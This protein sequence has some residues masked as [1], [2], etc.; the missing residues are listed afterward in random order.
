MLK[1]HSDARPHLAEFRLCQGRKILILYH[2]SSGGGLLQVVQATHQGRLSGTTHTDD[3]ID[4]SL[5]DIQ[6]DALQGLYLI[7]LTYKSFCY[8]LDLND[9]FHKFLHSRFA[10]LRGE[11]RKFLEFLVPCHTF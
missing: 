3:A 10:L 1:D 4:I 6:A 11:K 5:V 2:N 9:R 7:I 8:I